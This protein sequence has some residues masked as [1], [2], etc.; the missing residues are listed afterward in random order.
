MEA[1]VTAP[2]WRGFS[3]S[4]SAT[5]GRAISTPPFT[6]G[7]FVGNAAVDALSQGAFVIDHDQKLSLHGVVSWSRRGWFATT[8]MRHDSG[9]VVNPSDPE[10]VAGDPDYAD[11]LPWVNLRAITPRTRPRTITDLLVGYER[12]SDSRK[13]WE[14]SL[15][16][17]NALNRTALYNFQ[18]LFVGTRLVPPRAAGLRF[19]Y[20]F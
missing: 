20:F 3:A 5:H 7:L 4:L 18:S 9:L 11:V 16:V 8:S 6:G 12:R 15:Q 13:R 17:T 2:A 19:R 10:Q 1:R 14:A